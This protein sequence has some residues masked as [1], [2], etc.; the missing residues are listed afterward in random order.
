MRAADFYGVL[1]EVLKDLGDAADP[2][3]VA[4]AATKAGRFVPEMREIAAAQRAAGLTPALFE[5]FAEV[6]EEISA[7]DL[8]VGDPEDTARSAP[9]AEVVRRLRKR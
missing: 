1:D 5:A 6:Y 2:G 7:T 3:A 9:P 8:A 4:V